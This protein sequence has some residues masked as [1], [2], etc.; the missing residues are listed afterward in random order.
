V[1]VVTA[2]RVVVVGGRVVVTGGRTVVV[3]HHHPQRAAA[4]RTGV[5]PAVVVTG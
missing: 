5:A 2:G 1:V 4:A 3:G